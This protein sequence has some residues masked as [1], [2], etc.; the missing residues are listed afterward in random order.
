MEGEPVEAAIWEAVDRLA[1]FSQASVIERVSVFVRME[2]IRTEKHQT[3]YR[4]L[5]PYMDEKAIGEH[6]RPPKYTFTRRQREAWEALIEQAER[7]VNGE[8]EEG[9]Q[10][11]GRRSKTMNE[12]GRAR[13][14]RRARRAM[15]IMAATTNSKKPNG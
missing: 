8:E 13:R 15:T 4:P 3:R 10:E 5:Q 14:V 12:T 2:A 11:M 7:K 9:E 1:R 6:S